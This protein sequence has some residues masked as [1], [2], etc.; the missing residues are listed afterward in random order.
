[1]IRPRQAAE[2]QTLRAFILKLSPPNV[3][4][5]GPVDFVRIPDKGIRE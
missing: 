4:I 5:G 1:M 3:F 2:Y